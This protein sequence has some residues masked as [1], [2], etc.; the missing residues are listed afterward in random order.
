MRAGKPIVTTRHAGLLEIVDHGLG[1]FIIE[2]RRLD[3]LILTLKELI[4]DK[5]LR[6]R[7][8]ACNRKKFCTTFT[9][10]RHVQRWQ[11]L[12]KQLLDE[13]RQTNRRGRADVRH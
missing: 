3:Q 7:M 6:E 4:D 12:F 2:P 10:D 9:L 1:G 11:D 13:P 8:G 5:E